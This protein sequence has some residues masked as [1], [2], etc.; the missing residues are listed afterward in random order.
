MT[1]CYLLP[2]YSSD[3]LRMTCSSDL[4]SWSRLHRIVYML[5]AAN[6]RLN[7]TLASSIRALAEPSGQLQLLCQQHLALGMRLTCAND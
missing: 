1:L 3:W 6:G 2:G 7:V 4:E 5:N